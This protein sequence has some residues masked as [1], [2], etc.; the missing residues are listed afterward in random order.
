ME[1]QL[2]GGFGVKGKRVKG[3]FFGDYKIPYFL[4]VNKNNKKFFFTIGKTGV[5]PFTLHLQ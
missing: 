5:H 3:L 1:T 2:H 4:I